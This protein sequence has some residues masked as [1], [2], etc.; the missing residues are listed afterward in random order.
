MADPGVMFPPG[1]DPGEWL[2]TQRQMQLAQA[3]QQ[4]A[5]SP[6][7]ADVQQP[8]GGGKYYQ[9]A[10]VRPITALSK[11]AEAMMAKKGFDT[12]TP[13]M[14]Q[15]YGQAMGAFA[16]GGQT[17]P[18]VPLQ[19]QPPAQD[20]NEQSVQPALQRAPGASFAQTV[21][22]AQ[23]RQTPQNPMNPL[24]LPGSLAFQS[25]MK[26]PS[27]YAELIA[28]TPEFRTALSAAGGDPQLAMRMLQ[29]KF[30]KEGTVEARPGGWVQAPGGQWV[31]LPQGGPG[32][33]LSLGPG[34]EITSATIP[35][36]NQQAGALEGV[37][38][39]AKVANT[40]EEVDIGGG[41]KKLM[42]PG[43]VLPPPPVARP[44]SQAG[45][46]GQ[47]GKYF[48]APPTPRTPS[49]P[50]AGSTAA[51]PDWLKN[52]PKLNIPNTPGESTDAYTEKILGKAADK[53]I[54]L[55]DKYG[56]E[57]DLADARIA[58]NNE[59]LKVLH[60]ADTGPLS[61][62][63]TKLR[64]KAMELGVPA[65]WIPKSETVEN[66]QELKK[67]L[68]RNPLLS[69]K[70]TFGGRPAASEFAVLKEEAS[71]S[72][73]MLKSTIAKLVELDNEQAGYVKQRAQ[74]YGA[75][76]EAGKDPTRFESYYAHT[77][78]FAKALDQ[79]A[80]PAD[81]KAAALEEARRRGLIK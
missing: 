70:P 18:G 61:D 80:P 79:K 35:G 29:G 21:Q 34:G 26:D 68:L 49:A 22:G 56:S 57:A 38:T 48:G 69:L 13:K 12:S 15:Q 62:E 72:P 67:F 43:D 16:P 27:K 45:L 36:Y 28:G 23:T 64:A 52:A 78:P 81:A 8:A 31:Q 73:T 2:K 4:M 30:A 60:G 46:P 42:Y 75:Y 20:P 33:H 24:G 74:D 3:L 10:R 32:Q 58:F 77:H 53:H 59:A 25:Y 71:P 6:A 19:A 47:Q 65:S 40:P 51:Q 55:A 37:Q 7:Q 50:P 9:A 76:H 66:T 39:A 41:R 17:V 5:L 63:L 44:G 11:L 54:E 1:V 14:A